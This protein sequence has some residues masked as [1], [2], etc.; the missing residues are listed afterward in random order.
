MSL[1]SNIYS[2]L[3]ADAGVTA[4]VSDR[5]YPVVAPQGVT[6][7]FVVWQVIA[8]TGSTTLGADETSGLDRVLIQFACFGRTYSSA[9]D[10]C[11]AVRA[12]LEPATLADG[13]KCIF[14]TSRES[15]DPDEK[16]H[17]H[18]VDLIFWQPL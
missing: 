14:N 12:A 13:G 5:I 6:V 2:T 15:I 3:S 8:K 4:L 17:R 18:D 7:P 1:E 10:V 9:H 16:L 11:N